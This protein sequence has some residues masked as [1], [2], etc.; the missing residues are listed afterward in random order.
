MWVSTAIVGWPK[1]VLRITLAVFCR[2]RERFQCLARLRHL[3]AMALDQQPAGLQDVLRLG[4]VR[5][6]VRM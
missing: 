1:A 2:R 5:P 6:M 3:S 4:A